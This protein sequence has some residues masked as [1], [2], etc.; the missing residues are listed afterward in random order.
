MAWWKTADNTHEFLKKTGISP[1]FK[2]QC[3]NKALKGAYKHSKT[4]HKV[5]L[6]RANF[7]LCVNKFQT[8]FFLFLTY[9]YFLN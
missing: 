2:Q 3:Y 8:V 4:K 9:F 1:L 7:N 5:I 6:D